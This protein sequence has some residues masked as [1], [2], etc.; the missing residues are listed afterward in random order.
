MQPKGESTVRILAIGDIMGRPGRDCLEIG[1]REAKRQFS[2]DVLI[3]NGENAAGGF[4]ITEKILIQFLQEW[5]IHVITTGNHWADKKEI[6]GF[7]KK[8]SELLVPANMYNVDEAREGFVI[9]EWQPGYRYAVIN[10]LGR[11]FMKGENRCPFMTLDRILKQIPPAVKV[12]VVDFHAETSSEK[13]ALAQY[14]VGRVSLFYGTHTHCPTADERIFG[15]KTGF[16]TDLGM[17]GAYDSVIGIETD[18]SL[19]HF[20]QQDFKKFEP[21]KKDPWFCFLLADIDR[22]TGYCQHVARFRWKMSDMDSVGDQK[23]EIT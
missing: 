1:L 4:G 6:Y 7:K 15:G 2:P 17:T 22:T 20:L 21:S 9:K 3:A 14:S 13:Q 11:V 10:L 23:G 12:R 16:V 19:R 5:N 18:H 8:Y